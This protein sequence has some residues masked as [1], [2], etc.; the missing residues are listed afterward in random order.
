[1]RLNDLAL[2]QHVPHQSRRQPLPALNHQL[3]VAWWDD[4]TE[5][6]GRETE[7]EIMA[8]MNHILDGRGVKVH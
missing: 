5:V 6:D 1:M 7:D 2:D 4:A 8:R 3:S